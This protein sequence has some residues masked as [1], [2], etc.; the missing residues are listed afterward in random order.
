M[1]NINISKKKYDSLKKI[2][3]PKDIISTEATFYKLN[4]LG[5]VKVFKNL[6]RTSGPIFA[7]KLFI[8][9]ML[10]AYREI[11]PHNFILPESLVSVDKEIKGFILPFAN[12]INLEMYLVDKNVNI[13]DKLIAIQKIGNI[14]EQLSHIRKNSSLDSIYLLIEKVNCG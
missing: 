10:N 12:G 11:L 3:L 7:N 8:L 4:Y 14:L 1:N 2:E 13:K 6:Y 9:E 5:N